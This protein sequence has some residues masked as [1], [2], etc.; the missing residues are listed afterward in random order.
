MT[1]LVDT[2]YLFALTNQNDSS[3]PICAQF[4]QTVREPLVIPL[5]VLPEI[6]YLLDA[7]LGHRVM[8]P[9]VAQV[10]RPWWALEPITPPDLERTAELLA[11]YRDS[12]LD[13]VDAT[14]VALAFNLNKWFFF[15]TQGRKGAEGAGKGVTFASLRLCVKKRFVH[16]ICVLILRTPHQHQKRPVDKSTGRKKQSQH[17]GRC[18]A[19]PIKSAA[20]LP[21]ANTP[22]NPA[23]GC[24][25]APTK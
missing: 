4:A 20:I 23:P 25:P 10:A 11:Q 8:Q 7:R 21:E 17:H 6:A 3:H 12:R 13:F 24:V 5:T 1:I 9:F 19:C 18:Y 14:L 15:L 22:G 16:V 2:S